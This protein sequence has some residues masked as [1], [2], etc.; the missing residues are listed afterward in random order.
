M[1]LGSRTKG[2]GDNWNEML[3]DE[4][5]GRFAGYERPLLD[6]KSIL[7]E[8]KMPQHMVGQP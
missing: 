5:R 2:N 3:F 7:P 6:S 8:R 1:G 4:D